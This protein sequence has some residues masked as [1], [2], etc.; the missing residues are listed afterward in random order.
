MKQEKSKNDKVIVIRVNEKDK[1]QI[2]QLAKK[3]N[4][5]LSKYM[6]KKSKGN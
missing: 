5:T 1:G 6:I 4:L 2:Q 3:E